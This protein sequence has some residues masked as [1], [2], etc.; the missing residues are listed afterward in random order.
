MIAA[1]DGRDES[2]LR[3]R[4]LRDLGLCRVFTAFRERVGYANDAERHLQ[5][6]AYRMDHAGEPQ[7][8]QPVS[9]LS[10]RRHAFER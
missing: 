9:R 10:R 3:V 1:Y 8:R 5:D 2:V 6:Q 7:L 4:D